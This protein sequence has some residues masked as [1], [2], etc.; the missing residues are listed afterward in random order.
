MDESRENGTEAMNV[1][2]DHLGPRTLLFEFGVPKNEQ[3]CSDLFGSTTGLH[4]GMG[5]WV[6]RDGRG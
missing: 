1:A 5:T 4:I 3:M 6:L 2:K